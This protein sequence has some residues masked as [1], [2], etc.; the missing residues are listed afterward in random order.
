MRL[1]SAIGDLSRPH[2]GIFDERFGG[3]GH[4]SH[5]NGRDIDVYY[6]RLDREERAPTKPSEVDRVLA[7]D[8]VNRFV[9][10][11]ATNIFV[12]PRL[13]LRGPRR[14]VEPLVTTTTT[15]TFASRRDPVRRAD[16]SGDRLEGRPIEAV[17]VG[18]PDSAAAH[19][20]HRLHPWQRMRRSRGR[21]AGSTRAAPRGRPVD[22]AQPQPGRLRARP[23]TERARRRPEP[24]LRLGVEADGR[25]WSPEYPGPGRSRS[26]SRESPRRLIT[27]PPARRDDLVPPAA[28]AGPRVGAEHRRRPR[29]RAARRHAVPGHPVAGGDRAE[30]AEPSLPGEART[31][32]SFPPGRSPAAA[33]RSAMP[34]RSSRL[35]AVGSPACSASATAFLTA[36]SGSRPARARPSPTSSRTG[37]RSFSSSSSP[38]PRPERTSSSSCVTGERSS[39]RQGFSRSRSRATR[40]TRR[41]RLVQALDLDVPLALGLERRRDTGF[42][43]AH[44]YRGMKD[45]AERTAFLVAGAVRSAAHGATRPPERCPTSTS[46]SRPRR[47]CSARLSPST[48]GQA[49]SRRGPVPGTWTTSFWAGRGRRRARSRPEIT[50]RRATSSGS[51]GTRSSAV[52]NRGGTRTASSRRSSRVELRRAGRSARLLAAATRRSARSGPGTSS[53]CSASSVREAL[54]RSGFASCGYDAA[55]RSSA[56]S[57][58]ASLR[59]SWPRRAPATSSRGSRCCSRS[60]SS[61]WS[62]ASTAPRGGSP[63]SAAALVSIPLS[64]Q[65]HLALAAIPFFLL[66]ALLRGRGRD[67]RRRSGA[68]RDRR[69]PA[70]LRRCHPRHGRSRRPVVRPGR[71][72]LRRGAGL[73][74]ARR[75]V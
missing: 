26:G 28:G 60:R 23:A 14:I 39:S 45:V 7:Q 41:R 17:R 66:Y 16:R 61:P 49:S 52:A 57:R 22:R 44:E 19:P 74:L 30:L 56:A 62:E 54:R 29:I 47:R 10:A 48:S 27:R 15:C 25:R 58:S 4:A 55:L 3:L 6:P 33:A 24:Q 1:E 2:G 72:L 20:R 68:A 43:V 37:R 73:R 18:D 13:G 75:S 67:H 59:T 70:G 63:L 71:A 50:C 69:R 42:G 31:S 34:R 40:R 11:G 5:Q 46:C 53:C 65:L 9:R 51:S 36:R 38:G 21:R 8:L 35:L 64:G 12:G 32:S